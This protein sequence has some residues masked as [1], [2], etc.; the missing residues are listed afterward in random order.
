VYAG[1]P[2]RADAA[3]PADAEDT[4]GLVERL[5]ARL[6]QRWYPKYVATEKISEAEFR[7][8][9]NAVKGILSELDGDEGSYFEQLRNQMP[10]LTKDR[11][12][13]DY[14]TILEYMA[15]TA[16]LSLVRELSR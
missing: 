5:C 11:Y 12:R 13:Q 9:M 10:E 4:R 15:R 1:A 7:K 6:C 8:L 16:K 14:R 3:D 2:G